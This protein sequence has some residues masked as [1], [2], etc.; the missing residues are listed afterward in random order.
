[1]KQIFLL[2]FIYLLI[3]GTPAAAQKILLK[4]GTITKKL[5]EEV[6]AVDFRVSS[7]T[8]FSSGGGISVGK[9]QF[10]SL[11]IKKVKD[12]STN[13]IYKKLLSGANY[14]EV[15]LEYY[16]ASNVLYF[17]ITMKTVYIT[18]FYW[19]SPEC[20]TCIKLEHEIGFMPKTI[21]TRDEITG[22]IVKYDLSSGSTL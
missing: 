8:S 3:S 6:K 21:E 7:S 9:P 13:D 17:T 12:T 5:G 18:Q 16:D 20:P 14:P 4:I 11:L 1:M 22:T 15:L 19:L 2:L 10:N